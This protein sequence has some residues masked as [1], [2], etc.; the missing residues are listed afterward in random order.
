MCFEDKFLNVSNMKNVKKDRVNIRSEEFAY[1]T[2]QYQI[3]MGMG[4]FR[5]TCGL[6]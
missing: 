4:H 6:C 1:K 5:K 2:Q 3:K